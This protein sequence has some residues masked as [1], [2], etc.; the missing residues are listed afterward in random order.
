MNENYDDHDHDDPM[1]FWEG[2][3]LWIPICAVLWGVAYHLL[4]T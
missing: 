3:C 4:T 2:F 1:R